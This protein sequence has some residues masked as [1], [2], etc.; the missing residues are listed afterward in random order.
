MEQGTSVHGV[1]F[2]NLKYTDYIDAIDEESRNFTKICESVKLTG[3]AVW[4][5][6]KYG[7]DKAQSIINKKQDFSRRK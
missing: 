5:T 1:R 2:S 3:K 7:T 6:A 4:I